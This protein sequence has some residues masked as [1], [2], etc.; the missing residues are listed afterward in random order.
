MLAI[1]NLLK[2]NGENLNDTYVIEKIFWSLDSK[3]DYIVATI[4]EFKYL[5]F[6]II[7]QLRGSLQAHEERLKRKNKNKIRIN[8]SNK[9]FIKR[10]NNN[11][12]RS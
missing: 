10:K 11:N 4:E 2:R 1:V 7:N 6:I 12:E 5:D 8:S 3:F 9:P